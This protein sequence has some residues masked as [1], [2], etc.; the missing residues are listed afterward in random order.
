MTKIVGFH[1]AE[2]SSR[3]PWLR[4]HVFFWEG[5]QPADAGCQ[6]MNEG[7]ETV[8]FPKRCGHT[9]GSYG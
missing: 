7:D 9:E 5:R 4:S 2:R 8:F 6:L 3:R 1:H